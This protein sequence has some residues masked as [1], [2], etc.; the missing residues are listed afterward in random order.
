MFLR[1]FHPRQVIRLRRVDQPLPK[2]QELRQRLLKA[3]AMAWNPVEGESL[4]QTWKRIGWQPPGVVVTWE[5]DPAWPAA[6][7]LAADR[8]QPLVFLDTDF[9]SPNGTL[10]P[11][12]WQL[13]QTRVQQAVE[14]TGYA[15]ADLGDEIDTVTIVRQLAAK[16]QRTEK[17]KELL[18]V[19]DGLARHPGR[20][21][22][23]NYRLDLRFIC[24]S[25]LPGNVFHLPTSGNC[26]AL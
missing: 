24:S 9:G 5:N 20:S 25:C 8:G 14:D 12:Q 10:N 18:A 13:L 19:T 1:R 23:G 26:I 2:G 17:A 4:S 6:V 22:M 11:A 3:T 15:Y 7:S 21:A 16:Y